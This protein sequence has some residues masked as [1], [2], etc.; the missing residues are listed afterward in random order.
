M[1]ATKKRPAEKK[2]VMA[3][4]PLAWMN[5]P[6][7]AEIEQVP[8]VGQETPG[9]AILKLAEVLSIRDVEHLHGDLNAAFDA[10]GDVR[11]DAQELSHVDCAVAQLLTSFVQSAETQGRS[12]TWD[13][14]DEECRLTF[15]RLGLT[16]AAG[17]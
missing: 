4:D 2:K 11:F 14:P 12:V 16:E 1:A 7:S 13:G 15:E 17:L 8:D 10:G 9:P 6:P 3:D 5:E